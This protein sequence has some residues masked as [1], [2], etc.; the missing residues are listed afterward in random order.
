MFSVEARLR[1]IRFRSAI[2]AAGGSLRDGDENDHPSRYALPEGRPRMTSFLGRRV[3]YTDD[4]EALL[5]DG[6]AE[7]SP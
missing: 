2:L 3:V 5:A 4:G 1:A 6:P 7:P